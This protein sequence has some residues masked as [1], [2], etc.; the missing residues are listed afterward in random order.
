M[1]V[2]KFWPTHFAQKRQRMALS[3]PAVVHAY[4]FKTEEKSTDNANGN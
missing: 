4:C 3:G 2:A 1:C